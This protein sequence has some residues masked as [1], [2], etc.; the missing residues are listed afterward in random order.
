MFLNL[1]LI[2]AFAINKIIKNHIL[3]IRNYYQALYTINTT[4]ILS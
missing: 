1:A 3:L 2:L 4:K